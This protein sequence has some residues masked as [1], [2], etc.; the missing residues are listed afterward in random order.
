[1]CCAGTQYDLDRKKGRLGVI[2]EIKLKTDKAQTRATLT[3]KSF[4]MTGARYTINFL[5][6]AALCHEAAH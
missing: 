2:P 3:S 6:E 4:V 1:M 5:R